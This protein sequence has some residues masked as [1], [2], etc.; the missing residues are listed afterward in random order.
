M[1]SP[2]V[3]QVLSEEMKNSHRYMLMHKGVDA[4]QNNTLFVQRF[5]GQSHRKAYLIWSNLRLKAPELP[6]GGLF[7]AGRLGGATGHPPGA[8]EYTE[9]T[10]GAAGVRKQAPPSP[11][12]LNQP[13]KSGVLLP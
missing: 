10:R 9:K 3:L 4:L 12:V 6:G 5:V 13:K 2:S 8:G 7:L 11:P 1:P